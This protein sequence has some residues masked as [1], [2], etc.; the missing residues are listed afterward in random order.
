MIPIKRSKTMSK[1]SL[2][3]PSDTVKTVYFFSN[4]NSA[5]CNDKGLQIPDLQKPWIRLFVDFL[6]KKGVKNIENI[7]FDMPT[8]STAKWSEE[9]Q[10]WE[11]K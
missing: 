9:Y 10:N 4:G 11:L 5:V 1:E 7:E 8:G 3:K 6:K 2:G